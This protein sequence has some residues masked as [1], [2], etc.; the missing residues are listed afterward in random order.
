MSGF[1]KTTDQER[2]DDQ[3][4]QLR[5]T[6]WFGR[7]REAHEVANRMH[8]CPNN[9]RNGGDGCN[10]GDGKWTDRRWGADSR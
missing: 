9:P 3:I 8:Q 5:A 4:D 2:W 10:H 6:N 1:R 7:D